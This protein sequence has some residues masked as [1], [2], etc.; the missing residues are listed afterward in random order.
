[1]FIAMLIATADANSII[2]ARHTDTLVNP[3]D[4]LRIQNETGEELV[5]TLQT[6]NPLGGPDLTTEL[7]RVGPYS[8]RIEDVDTYG[9]VS[10]DVEC[11]LIVESPE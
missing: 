6:P 2:R 8:N 10:C 7:A 3:M 9:Y 11:L 5:V 4:R 1:M